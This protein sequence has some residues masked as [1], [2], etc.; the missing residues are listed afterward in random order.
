MAPSRGIGGPLQLILGDLETP[1][2]SD[3]QTLALPLFLSAAS[4][5]IPDLRQDGRDKIERFI[6]LKG[7][8]AA[9]VQPAQ[10]AQAKLRHREFHLQ[11]GHLD[12]V[13]LRQL[14]TPTELCAW[15]NRRATA[16]AAV[17]AKVC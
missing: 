6:Q 17:C 1:A 5:Q 10:F 3:Q 7:L 12:H 15:W 16:S 14:W 4:R 8:C 13:G 9:R 11:P 2:C